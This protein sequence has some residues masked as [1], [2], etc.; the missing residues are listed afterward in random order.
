[1]DAAAPRRRTA[2]LLVAR[3]PDA[4]TA[5]RR[6]GGLSLAARWAARAREAGQALALFAPGLSRWPAVTRDDFARVG[7]EPAIVTTVEPG[8]TVLDAR[9]L[10]D[11]AALR[12]AVRGAPVDHA[13]VIDLADERMAIRRLVV[14]TAKPSDGVVSRWLNRPVSQRITA[15][16]LRYAPF[17]RPSHVTGVVG[18]VALVMALSLLSG[19]ATGLVAG[20][21][22]FHVAS[23][24][25]GVDGELARV[26]YRSSPEG[27]VLDTR[28]D[29][30]TNIGFFVCTAVALTRLYGGLQAAVGGM[31][32]ML[33][34]LGLGIVT[35][36]AKRRGAHGSLDVLKP[37][38]RERFPDGWQYWVTEALVA[39]TSRDFFAFAFAM[40][41]V[42]GYGWTV[43]WLLLGFV[44]TWLAAVVC[45]M[46][47]VLRQAELQT[48]RGI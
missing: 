43:S 14:A 21:I 11:P 34:L 18:T 47:G 26:S 13:A 39:A 8:A 29:L 35:W 33:A 45:A 10:P 3:F 7:L 41:I 16:L 46:P 27:A 2:P 36:L 44:S 48:L 4:A 6:L 31:A 28:V 25:D 15:M 38:Y 19:T 24:L 9:Y 37:Y 12:A 30:L 32:V 22:L 40:V 1:M 5:N 17:V 42:L 23:V 20:G